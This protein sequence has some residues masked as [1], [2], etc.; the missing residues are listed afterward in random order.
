MSR[1]A[2]KPPLASNST[3]SH[4]R[5]FARGA[6][7]GVGLF[8]SLTFAASS[9]AGDVPR[10]KLPKFEKIE[11]V[12]RQ[13]LEADGVSPFDLLSQGNVAGVLAQLNKRGWKVR[14]GKKIVGSVLP[15]DSF[16][17]QRLARPDAQGFKQKVAQMPDGYDRVDRLIRMPHGKKTINALVR[18]PDGYKMIEY[19]TT[20]RGGTQLGK[21]LA[22]APGGKGFNK[23]T[24]RIYTTSQLLSRLKQS[25]REELK[26][27]R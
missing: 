10:R 23:P 12:V 9:V 25:Y 15:D 21:S 4:A 19:M 14:D 8:L 16:L 3:Q 1:P 5:L 22:E 20:S 7:R 13:A 17:V 24:G 18:G 6:C 11:R 26:Q 2:A 27:S